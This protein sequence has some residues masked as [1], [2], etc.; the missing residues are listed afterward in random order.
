MKVKGELINRKNLQGSVHD[1]I[2]RNTVGI[3]LEGLRKTLVL[4]G[5][6]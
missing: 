6:Q 4:V 5:F 1:V 2:L 3:R